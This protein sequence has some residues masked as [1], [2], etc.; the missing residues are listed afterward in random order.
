MIGV[1]SDPLFMNHETG[2]YHP[3]T[4]M[5]VHYIH[6]LF[7]GKDPGI[8]MIDPVPASIEDIKLNHAKYY[9]DLVMRSCSS[10]RY[11]DL[12]PDTI[13]SEDSYSVALNA[14]GSLIR[15]TELAISGEIEAGFASVR[16][17]G[18]HA[19]AD[20]AM[21][22]CLF[23]NVAIAAHKAIRSFG[24]K[25]VLIVDFDVH[26]GN[27]TQES[28]YGSKDVLYFSTHQYP[29]YPGTGRL[30]DVGARGAEGFTVNCPLRSGK[31][32]G[33]YAAVYRRVL[34]PVVKAFKPGL[35]LVSA[36]FDAHGMDPIG[37]MQ[38]SSMGFAAIAGMIRDAAGEAGAPVV[39]VLEGGYNLDALRDS[40][41][42][43]V[44]VL[45]G[46]EVPMVKETVWPELDEIIKAHSR[47]WPL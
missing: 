10:N 23:N 25:K 20:E 13:C 21:G 1:V 31:N 8:L 6:T 11:T 9:I 41:K 5:R 33:Q 39:Y 47:Y 3:E 18:H 44:N 28:F 19:T 43:V 22:F 35:V 46:G 34:V 26:H 24:V 32:D 17:P 15:L 45:K 30:A 14:A 42:A 36:G 40:V 7:A 27:G 38:L 29:F 2:G 16:P 37:G 4:P 12:D